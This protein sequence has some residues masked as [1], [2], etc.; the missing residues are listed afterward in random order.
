MNITIHII[1]ILYCSEVFNL[2]LRK[3]ERLKLHKGK[4]ALRNI[5]GSRRAEVNSL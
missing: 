4:K 2:T 5:F 1:V 3:E